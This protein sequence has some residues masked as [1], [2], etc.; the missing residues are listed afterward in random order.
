MDYAL[1]FAGNGRKKREAESGRLVRFAEAEIGRDFRREFR[2]GIRGAKRNGNGRNFLL[3]LVQPRF[4]RGKTNV[5]GRGWASL[6]RHVSR[7]ERYGKIFVEIRKRA[8]FL[9]SLGR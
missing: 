5:H 4:Y 1:R 6:L 7:G 9:R 8:D 2:Q 3:Q